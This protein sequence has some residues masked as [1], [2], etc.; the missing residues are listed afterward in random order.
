[1]VSYLNFH[2]MFFISNNLR[3]II[4]VCVDHTQQSRRTYMQGKYTLFCSQTL[5]HIERYVMQTIRA[6]NTQ[7]ISFFFHIPYTPLH[8]AYMNVNIPTENTTISG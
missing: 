7:Q 3:L 8:T 4:C 2:G 5:L 1:M 6:Y